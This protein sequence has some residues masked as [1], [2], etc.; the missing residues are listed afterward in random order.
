M[1]NH[2]ENNVN[3]LVPVKGLIIDFFATT[4]KA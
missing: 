3:E 4:I 1:A 2:A